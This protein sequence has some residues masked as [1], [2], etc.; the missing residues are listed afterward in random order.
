MGAG[1]FFTILGGACW[2]VMMGI[3][4]TFGEV[5]VTN[6][7]SVA[8]YRRIFLLCVMSGVIALIF[9][10]FVRETLPGA[11]KERYHFEE[12]SFLQL[13]PERF[14]AD[15]AFSIEAVAHGDDP[16][17]F[18]A[19]LRGVLQP[20]GRL[21]LIDDTLSDR[22]RPEGLT[23]RQRRLLETY[24]RHWLLPGLRDLPALKA[25]AEAQG[26]SL[27]KDQNLT[28][29]LRLRRPRDK[30]IS[31][32]V[33]LMGSWMERGYYRRALLG[34]DAKQKCYL[35]GLIHYRL[36]VFKKLPN[37]ASND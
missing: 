7:Y 15:F 35:A 33:R 2:Q 31:W 29:Y 22:S 18:F 9:S 21:V 13:D 26:F 27:I 28:P 36:L 8:G 34:G 25:F 6:V 14:K 10:F 3:A 16:E 17:A 11:Q 32:W 20:G 37:A 5:N 23:D 1:N 24:Q 4:V 12:G 19:A 30:L